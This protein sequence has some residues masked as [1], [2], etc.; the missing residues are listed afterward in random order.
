MDCC[1]MPMAAWP[2]G[3]LVCRKCQAKVGVSWVRDRN[4]FARCVENPVVEDMA[5]EPEP[6]PVIN[7][8]LDYGVGQGPP[9]APAPMAEK[10]HVGE[11]KVS[12]FGRGIGR[13]GGP[14]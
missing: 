14:K 11:P 1:G 6:I 12:G 13:K 5:P 4:P 10:F 3:G 2:G 8:G 9:A 7:R